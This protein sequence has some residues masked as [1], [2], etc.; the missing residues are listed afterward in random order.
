[1][2]P[3]RVRDGVLELSNE[4]LHRARRLGVRAAM[5]AYRNR[6]LIHYSQGPERWQGIERHLRSY[7]GEFPT[8]ADCSAFVTWVLWDATLRWHP[9]DFVNGQRWRAGHTGTLDDKGVRV[10]LANLRPLDLV[11][12]GDEGWRPGHVAIVVDSRHDLV[13]SHGSEGGPYLLPVNYRSDIHSA[14]RYLA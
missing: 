9:P 6:Q 12:Y 4:E 11:F 2:T 10:G 5:L 7:R 8:E 3:P 13:V 1:M 14:R